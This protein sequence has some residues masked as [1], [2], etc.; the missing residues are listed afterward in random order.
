[1]SKNWTPEQ[2][3]AIDSRGKTLL[4]SAAAGSGK[5][6]TLTERIV[7]KLTDEEYNKYIIALKDE[8][9]PKIIKDANQ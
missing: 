1:M 8:E 4:V 5:T 2:R 3:Q 7:K 6:A 9:P